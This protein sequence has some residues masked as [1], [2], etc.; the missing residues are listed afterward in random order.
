MVMLIVVIEVVF[1][2]LRGWFV[3]WLLEVRVGVYVGNV[4]RWVWEMIWFYIIELVDE[5]NVV[6]VWFINNEFGFEF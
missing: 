4:L 5:G 2:R 6:M 1:Y 3:V